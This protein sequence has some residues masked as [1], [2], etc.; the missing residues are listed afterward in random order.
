MVIVVSAVAVFGVV[1]SA[2]HHDLGDYF[3]R[4][5]IELSSFVSI[6]FPLQVCVL[7][8]RFR[9]IVAIVWNI[10]FFIL[11]ARGTKTKQNEKQ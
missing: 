1:L 7:W 10:F 2:L 4:E 8:L 5:S 9:H 3:M 11:L 6:V